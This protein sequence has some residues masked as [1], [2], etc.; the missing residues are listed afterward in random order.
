MENLITCNNC[1]MHFNVTLRKPMILPCCHDTICLECVVQLTQ[2]QE[3]KLICP[4]ENRE[5]LVSQFIENIYLIKNLPK[6]NFIS[7]FCDKHP[8][9]QADLYCL[10]HDILICNKCAIL[11]H[12]DHV[13]SLKDIFREDLANFCLKANHVIDEEQQKLSIIKDGFNSYIDS[14]IASEINLTSMQF[15][16][17]VQRFKRIIKMRAVERKLA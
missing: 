16:Q 4:F 9:N 1:R 7:I 14:Y 12:N 13:E 11:E 2:P 10:E 8:N 6:I 5:V 15:M 3:N 17:M